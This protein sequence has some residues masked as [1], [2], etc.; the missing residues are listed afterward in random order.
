MQLDQTIQHLLRSNEDLLQM[1]R[2][3]PRS[4]SPAANP[5]AARGAVENN[6]NNGRGRPR[7]S[8]ASGLPLS[9]GGGNRNTFGSSNNNSRT[10]SPLQQP[11]L[12][13]KNALASPNNNSSMNK[14]NSTSTLY[15]KETMSSMQRNRKNGAGA[16]ADTIGNTSARKTSSSSMI[17]YR[18]PGNVS[19]F[20]RLSQPQ[21]SCSRNR[22]VSPP[23][24]THGRIA[25]GTAKNTARRFF[26]QELRSHATDAVPH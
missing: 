13:Y 11:P 19:T 8:S 6:N 9:G 5:A 2:I 22:A 14:L 1:L 7:P 12:H 23:H 10:S 26:T 25:H 15:Q 17:Q 4:N 21:R 20:E 3:T 24:C 18:D 16:N